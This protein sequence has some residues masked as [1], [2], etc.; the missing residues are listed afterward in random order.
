MDCHEIKNLLYDEALGEGNGAV[1]D[2]VKT[3]AACRAEL[4]RLQTTRKLMMQGLPEE[5]PARRIAFVADRPAAPNPLRFWQWSFA[6]AA[7]FALFFAVLA[8]RRPDAPI[9]QG[10]ATQA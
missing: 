6:G 5:E 10:P 8:V 9:A 1:K 3:C 4:E 2:H 7:A